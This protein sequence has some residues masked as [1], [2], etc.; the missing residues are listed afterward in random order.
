MVAEIG[1]RL[2]ASR[3]LLAGELAQLQK[4][5]DADGAVLGAATELEAVSLRAMD[6]I[7]DLAKAEGVVFAA[8][9]SQPVASVPAA[10]GLAA[11]PDKEA[12]PASVDCELLEPN[13]ADP[14]E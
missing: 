5:V 14:R 10:D 11:V 9:P 7:E 1:R 8:R 4:L 12:R 6:A 3:T 2:R 13:T